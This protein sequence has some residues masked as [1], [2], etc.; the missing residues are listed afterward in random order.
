MS[1][2]E[3]KELRK[4]GE[5]EN[6]LT[7]AQQDLEKNISDIWNK[8][9]IAWV[10]YEFLKKYSN[11]E[12]YDKFIDYLK[13]IKSLELSEDENMIFDKCSFQVGKMLFSLSNESIADNSKIDE[14]FNLVKEFH[15]TKP[16][17]A[18]SYI[19]KAFNKFHKTWPN[20]LNFA[21]WWGYENFSSEDFIQTEYNGKKIMSLAEQG[22]ISYSKKLLEGEPVESNGMLM[23]NAIN[24]ELV[25][26]FLSKLEK[27]IKDHPEYQYP[28]YFRAK[29]LM[30]LGEDTYNV[31]TSFLPFAKQKKNDFWVWTLFAEIY[32]E[33]KELSFSCYC[34]ALSLRTSEA[35]LVKVHQEFAEML[36]EKEMF[37]EAKTEIER[38]ISVREK[39]GWKISNQL[40]QWQNQNWYNKATSKDSNHDL[41]LKYLKKAEKILYQDIKEE[42]IAVEFVNRNKKIL[43]FVESEK[44]S[45][46]FKYSNFIKNPQIGNILK[47]RF[48]GPGQ[49][50][51]FKILSLEKAGDDVK[52]EAIKEFR[53]NIRISAFRKFGFVENI[54]VAPNLIAENNIENDQEIKGKAI[55]SFNKKKEE[56][57]WKAFYVIKI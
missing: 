51:Y 11:A 43:N 39:E 31:L 8:R 46:F 38:I 9:S 54:F 36:I 55:L 49:D 29:F 35:F 34:K 30:V 45:G 32:S 12:N 17:G 2:K 14:L 57:G 44:I 7:L 52:S 6:A 16:S 48:D 26:E 25:N 18:Y 37:S 23:N 42:V 19:F 27:I 41:Y 28:P 13:K 3:V 33:D 47:V 15:P 22:Y 5:L 4:S 50:G 21:D 20:F 1:F 40:K 10:Y 24:K 53:G 56:W